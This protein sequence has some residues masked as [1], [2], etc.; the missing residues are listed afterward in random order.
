M[1]IVA[2]GG[3][4]FLGRRVVAAL[5]GEHQVRVLSRRV[6]AGD[7]AAWEPEREPP[8]DAI[9]R[10][11]D[12]VIHLAGEPVAQRWTAEAK[13]RIRDSRRLGTGNLVAGL[14]RAGGRVRVLVSASAIGI[15]GSRG[16]E[17]LTEDSRPGIGFL[18]EVCA[19]WEHEAE[20]AERLG[21]RVARLRIGIVLAPDGGALA[22]MLPPFRMGVGGR[23]GSGEQ[24]MSWI[25]VDDLV[26]LV[27]FALDGGLR[28]AVNATAPEPVRNRDF[29]H[30]LAQVLHRPA[31]LPVPAPAL[32]LMFGEMAE[33]L[34][35]SQRVVP[36]A[37]QEAGFQFRYSRLEEALASLSL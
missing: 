10:E 29:T 3:T 17:T 7:A 21:V 18:P 28:G 5:A 4:G 6:R 11:A 33:V 14:A 36:R 22:R 16:E 37:A 30:A 2:T 9:L 19:A 24:W 26:G 25:H 31:F 13:R 15:Y 20:A 23:L 27:R 1:N 32:R 35:G 12:A 34:L 8:P